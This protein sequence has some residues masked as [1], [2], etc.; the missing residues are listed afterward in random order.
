MNVLLQL[1]EKMKAVIE[2]INIGEC[3][4][5]NND[6]SE[7]LENIEQHYAAKRVYMFEASLHTQIEIAEIRHRMNNGTFPK[8]HVDDDGNMYWFKNELEEIR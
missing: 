8:P 4:F 3:P 5:S 7:I 2:Q 1:R 6:A